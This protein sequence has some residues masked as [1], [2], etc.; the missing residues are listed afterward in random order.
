MEFL[1]VLHDVKSTPFTIIWDLITYSGMETHANAMQ[2]FYM[3]I[4]FTFGGN[5][6]AFGRKCNLSIRKHTSI[7]SLCAFAYLILTAF[8]LHPI[9]SGLLIFIEGLIYYAIAMGAFTNDYLW[10]FKSSISSL[11]PMF[12]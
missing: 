2:Q 7:F 4:S 1:E 10:F 11:L 9:V 8:E 5:H 6:K 3:R 12:I